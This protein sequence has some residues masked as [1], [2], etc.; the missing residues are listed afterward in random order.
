MTKKLT[1]ALAITACAVILVAATVMG[2]VAY[3]TSQATMSNTFA[4]GNVTITMD[5]IRTDEYGV[6]ITPN[7]R[8]TAEVK[9]NYKLIPAATYNKDTT[10]HIKG[11]SEPCYL[12][13]KLDESFTSGIISATLTD[14]WLP[15][16]GVAGVY[17][18]TEEA[19][20]RGVNVENTLDIKV[21]ESF[22]VASTAKNADVAPYQGESAQLIGYATQQQGL[23]L[24][25][26]WTAVSTASN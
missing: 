16:D 4:A 19:D 18:Y 1:K 20:A 17:Y 13:V 7:E 5:D 25:E 22:T 21:M 10:I 9:N 3:L 6:A 12:F 26:A 14:K 2:T 11:G 15:L 24:A 23:T 8:T